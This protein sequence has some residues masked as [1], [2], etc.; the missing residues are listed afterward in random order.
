MKGVFFDESLRDI[1]LCPP[2]PFNL[3]EWRE[4]CALR[5]KFDPA[6]K[7]V[8]QRKFPEAR[9]EFLE[10]AGEGGTNQRDEAKSRFIELEESDDMKS[11]WAD[12]TKRGY[13]DRRLIMPVEDDKI[14]GCVQPGIWTFRMSNIPGCIKFPV[15]HPVAGQLYIGHPYRPELYVPLG[16]SSLTFFHDKL[17][18]LC[19]LLQCLGAEEIVLTAI[20][21]KGISETSSGS[22]HADGGLGVKAFSGSG[23]YD[24]TDDRRR[25]S[26]MRDERTVRKTFDPMR[27]PFVPDDLVWFPEQPQWERLVKQRMQGNMLEYSEIVSTKQTNFVSE[28]ETED[29]KAKAQFLWAKAEVNVSSASKRE[30]RQSEE[31]EWKVEARFR[32]MREF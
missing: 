31:T 9:N 1:I 4:R 30:F 8:Q 2:P 17:D 3:K 6:E 19:Y 10:L 25:D 12:F 32:S 15:C 28:S 14:W 27:A 5:E 23:S 20:S 13:R 22:S 29:V 26:S 18:E 16:E 11:I 21:G 7:F 24:S